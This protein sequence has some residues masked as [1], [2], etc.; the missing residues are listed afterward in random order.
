MF[1]ALKRAIHR[2]DTARR[3]RRQGWSGIYVGDYRSS[4][5]W[6]YTIGFLSSLGAPEVIVFDVPQRSANG[7]FGTVFEELKAGELVLRD[8]EAWKSAAH[9]AVWREVHPSRYVDEE[10]PWL[11]IAETIAAIQAGPEFRAFQL[12]LSDPE[13]RLPWEPQ[14]DERLR[15]LQRELYLPA[16]EA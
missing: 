10:Q 1:R 14:Y 12:V 4:P 16:A 11:G 6:A 8:G 15:P 5:S 13:G 9:P 7:I 2:W 3:V